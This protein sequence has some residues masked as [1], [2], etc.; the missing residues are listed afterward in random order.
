MLLSAGSNNND[1]IYCLW[2]ATFLSS[3]LSSE[4]LLQ[5]LLLSHANNYHTWQP[6]APKSLWVAAAQ[7]WHNGAGAVARGRSWRQP[8]LQEGWG[9]PANSCSGHKI[10][11]S[12]LVETAAGPGTQPSCWILLQKILVHWPIYQETEEKAGV[13][14]ADCSEGRCLF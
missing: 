9:M 8:S 3:I 2:K 14:I 4:H 13:N 7:T 12:T 5:C 11:K 10:T 6:P 1:H